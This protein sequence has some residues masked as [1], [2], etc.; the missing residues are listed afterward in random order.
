M[1]K[2]TMKLFYYLSLSLFTALSLS[3]SISLS[4]SLQCYPEMSAVS[5]RVTKTQPKGQGHTNNTQH[6]IKAD[7]KLDMSD[8]YSDRKFMIMHSVMLETPGVSER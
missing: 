5:L 1:R 6:V 8:E 7:E 2:H 3:L 4:L